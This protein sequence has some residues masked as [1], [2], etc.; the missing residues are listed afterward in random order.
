MCKAFDTEE[1]YGTNRMKESKRARGREGDI[2]S[3][4]ERE[5]G[6]NR[7]RKREGKNYVDYQ[8]NIYES[9]E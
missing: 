7:E 3:E 8:K 6:R 2:N 9:N 4:R 1:E 5:K